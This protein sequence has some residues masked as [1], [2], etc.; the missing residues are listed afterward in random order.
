M[1][2]ITNFGELTES[3][4]AVMLSEKISGRDPNKLSIIFDVDVTNDYCGR[5]F[6][7]TALTVDRDKEILKICMKEEKD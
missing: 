2:K 1:K 7:I 5:P 3:L 6:R 4:Y